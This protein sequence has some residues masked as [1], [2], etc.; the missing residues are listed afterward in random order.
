MGDAAS[1]GVG[2][3]VDAFLDGMQLDRGGQ[4]LAATCRSLAAKLDGCTASESATA[5]QSPP[6]LASQLVEVITRLQA[7]APR[8][9]DAIDLI[10]QRRAARLASFGIHTNNNGR[11]YG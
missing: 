5:A 9:P 3:A 10:Q 2:A 7:T 11:T 6:R 8:E 4:V 1:T